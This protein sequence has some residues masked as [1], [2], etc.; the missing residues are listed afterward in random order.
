MTKVKKEKKE[1]MISFVLPVYNEQ[2]NIAKCIESLLKQEGKKEIIII[3]DGSTD[4]THRIISHYKD[5]INCLN[6]YKRSGAARC[7][8]NGNAIAKGDIISVCDAEI[9]YKDRSKMIREFFN[10]NPD[11]G[12][13]YTSLH[14]RMGTDPY[15]KYLMEAYEWD[16][17]SKCPISHPTIAYRKEVALKHPYHVESK[18]T[19]LFEFMLLNMHKGGVKFG[20]C[21]DASMLK[22]E[23]N[24]NRDMEAST[25]LKINKYYEEFIVPIE[26]ARNKSYEEKCCKTALVIADLWKD[27]KTI[28]GFFI[29]Y[30]KNKEEK[31]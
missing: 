18:E 6:N 24:A 12:V 30:K 28:E 8:N 1:L 14:L 22:I 2:N 3:N 17:D 26:I 16:F 29:D 10:E 27:W 15:Q 19:D 23:G 25:K 7:R 13:F 21:Q 5:K 11:K 4:N 9:Y 20:G 31:K